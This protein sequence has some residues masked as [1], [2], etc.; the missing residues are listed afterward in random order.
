MRHVLLEAQAGT[1]EWGEIFEFLLFFLVF[2][3]HYTIE[4]KQWSLA[5]PRC[6]D[7]RQ[8]EGAVEIEVIFDVRF[9]RKLLPLD[10]GRRHLNIAHR[11]VEILLN[12]F[13]LLALAILLKVAQMRANEDILAVIPAL[14]CGDRMNPYHVFLC[15]ADSF[16]LLTLG[17]SPLLE[18]LQS[19]LLLRLTIDRILR[20][21]APFA[22]D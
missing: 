13:I 12:D 16:D 22:A 14:V 4:A 19:R 11:L 10:L 6:I 9:S 20:R 2:L 15:E 3:I 8:T 1:L 21:L 7:L 17:L 5:D 18:C